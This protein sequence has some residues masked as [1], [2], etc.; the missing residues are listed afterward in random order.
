MN[1]SNQN[2]HKTKQHWKTNQTKIVVSVLLS[3]GANAL[4]KDNS[5]KSALHHSSYKTIPYVER[6]LEQ[7]EENRKKETEKKKY[8]Q[9]NQ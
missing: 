7:S 5:G 9:S 4:L 2:K 3:R 6:V 8:K 1:D